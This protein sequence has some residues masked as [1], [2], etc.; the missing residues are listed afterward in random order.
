MM[1]VAIPIW[2]N[3]VS[4][5]FDTSGQI[6]IVEI[7]N[8]AETDRQTITFPSPNPAHRAQVLAQSGVDVL[9]CGAISRPLETMLLSLGIDVIPWIKGE[10]DPVIRAFASGNLIAENF[11]LPGCRPARRRCRGGG[12]GRRLGRGPQFKGR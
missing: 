7:V 2:D 10:T 5:V 1:K 6:L 4:P 9:I 8:N 12:Q 11:S 3:R